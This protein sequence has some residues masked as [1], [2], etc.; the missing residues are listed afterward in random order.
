M[1]QSLYFLILQLFLLSLLSVWSGQAVSTRARGKKKLAK[2]INICDIE[3]QQA[4]IYCYCTNDDLRNAT[5]AN[6]LVLSRFQPSDVMWSYF[7]SQIYLQK[8]TFTVRQAGSLDYIPTQLLHQL[9]NLRTIVFQYAKIQE[10]AEHTFSNLTGL[11]EINLSRNLIVTLRKY[12]FENMRN[13][14]LINLDENRISE[15]NRLVTWLIIVNRM[16]QI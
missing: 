3:G 16:A 9:K 15:I 2:E 4:P 10:L 14:T 6:C 7:T 11:S 8:L 1:R 12:A 5:N 13:L